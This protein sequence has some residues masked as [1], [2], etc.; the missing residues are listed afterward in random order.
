[1]LFA[2]RHRPPPR[3][4]GL[5]TTLG[6]MKVEDALRLVAAAGACGAG[7][8]VAQADGCNQS[9]SSR[10]VRAQTAAWGRNNIKLAESR[11]LGQ[12]DSQA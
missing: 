3:E 11:R 6:S 9:A 4:R 12:A 1:V 8:R 5:R 10:G 7:V 2:L